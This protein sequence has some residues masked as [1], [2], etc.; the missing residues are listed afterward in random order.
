MYVMYVCRVIIYIYKN[1]W[2]LLSMSVCHSV[3]LYNYHCTST[4]WYYCLF[5]VP[6]AFTNAILLWY[7]LPLLLCDWLNDWRIDERFSLCSPYGVYRWK[8]ICRYTNTWYVSIHP[9]TNVAERFAR[10]L[11]NKSSNFRRLVQP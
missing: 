6:N 10:F 7:C 4:A 9:F 3:C 8:M 5:Q 11:L 1:S 2:I